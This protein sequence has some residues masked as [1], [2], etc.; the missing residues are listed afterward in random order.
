MHH[1]MKKGGEE[2][3]QTFSCIRGILLNVLHKNFSMF[4][5]KCTMFNTLMNN[6]P[7]T[8]VF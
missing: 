7:A 4:G 8:F 2:D 3:C 6:L 5:D 1:M